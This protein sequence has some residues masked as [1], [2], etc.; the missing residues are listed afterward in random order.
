MS[1]P[2]VTIITP[3]YNLIKEKREE[4]FRTCLESV[5]NQTYE[6]VEHIII[7]TPGE[8]DTLNLIN[9]YV[10]KGYVQC[11]SEEKHG[12]Y[13]AMNAA[14]D[15]A[16]GKYIAFLNSDDFF[17]DNKAIEYS[18]SA[19]EKNNADF[20]YASTLVVNEENKSWI[21][22]D[23]MHKFLCCM[24]F[25]H[26]TMFTKKDV[27][28]AEGKFN[29]KYKIVADNNLIIKMMFNNRK[30]VYI[31]KNIVTFNEGGIS[32]KQ[33]DLCVNER[34]EIFMDLYQDFYLFEDFNQAKELFLGKHIPAEFTSSFR[35]Y[36][37][38]KKLNNYNYK[39]VYKF[40]EMDYSKKHSDKIYS[41]SERARNLFVDIVS[42][43]LIKKIKL[44][45]KCNYV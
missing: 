9:E 4:S 11:F 35:E 30:F 29:T 45:L 37:K 6:N 15:F 36:V 23:N 41:L 22:D 20:S 12:V 40:L 34:A 19:L 18:I 26:Q 28:L 16:S 27:L 13:Y 44:T 2:R 25:C 43:K 1:T 8:D 32:S 21:F 5:Y 38:Q 14:I 33:F 7:Y 24:P 10:E 42:N 31:P 17:N 3:V 39:K